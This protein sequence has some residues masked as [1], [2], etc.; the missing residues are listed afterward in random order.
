MWS[1]QLEQAEALHQELNY[2]V[3][4]I[5]TGKEPF[6][7]GHAGLRVVRMLEAASKSMSTKG[8]FVRL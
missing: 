1:P 7:N 6:N 2:F 3:D 4:C 8:G 5:S